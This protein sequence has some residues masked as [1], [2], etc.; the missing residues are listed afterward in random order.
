MADLLAL[1][2]TSPTTCPRGRSGE[3][4]G[5]S[6]EGRRSTG[7]RHPAIAA[8]T[9]NT[10]RNMSMEDR[11]FLGGCERAQA[12][13]RPDPASLD[14][15][16][17]RCPRLSAI[18]GAIAGPGEAVRPDVVVADPPERRVRARHA[19]LVLDVHFRPDAMAGSDG[20]HRIAEHRNR[21]SHR[22]GNAHRA[23]VRRDEPEPVAL[24]DPLLRHRAGPLLLDRRS[25]H[26]WRKDVD[27]EVAAYR[28]S[29][30]RAGA[31]PGPARTRQEMSDPPCS[32]CARY[33]WC[34]RRWP[35]AVHRCYACP[36]GSFRYSRRPSRQGRLLATWLIARAGP[37]LSSLRSR[38]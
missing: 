13:R 38:S 17:L 23:Q 19:E 20:R 26:G 24:A 21:P 27:S 3:S 4:S 15:Q 18:R 11:S 29:P 33:S 16:P 6:P 10:E 34:G 9:T 28:G 30:D 25:L 5:T 32:C 8:H 22:G 12:P 31:A 2:T 1:S 37:P 36:R 14:M 35:D 7:G